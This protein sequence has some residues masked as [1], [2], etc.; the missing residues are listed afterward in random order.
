MFDNLLRRLTTAGWRRG[1]SG[2][3]AWMIVGTVAAGLR[4]VRF[5][6]RDKEE[7][8]YR[9]R[10]KPGDHFEITARPAARR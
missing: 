5:V 3:R 4:L 6:T 10:V 2:S 9:T 1:R 8:V 7:V